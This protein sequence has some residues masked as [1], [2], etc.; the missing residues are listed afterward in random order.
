VLDCNLGDW[1]LL[2]PQHQST[3]CATFVI[4]HD[5]SDSKSHC[6]NQPTGCQLRH[7]ML[8]CVFQGGVVAVGLAA[9]AAA[10]CP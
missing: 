1:Q 9:V 7:H 6:S 3:A 8:R 5:G 2:H 4:D 10:V